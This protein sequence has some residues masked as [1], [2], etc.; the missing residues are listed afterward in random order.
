[1][2]QERRGHGASCGMAQRVAEA[3]QEEL[4]E[5]EPVSYLVPP[6]ETRPV[7][8]PAEKKKPKPRARKKGEAAKAKEEFP[9]RSLSKLRAALPFVGLLLTFLL[10]CI[11]RSRAVPDNVSLVSKALLNEFPAYSP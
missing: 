9:V 3:Q 7:A 6:E 1:M 11:Q 4:E 5:C 10:Y 8:G 2:E